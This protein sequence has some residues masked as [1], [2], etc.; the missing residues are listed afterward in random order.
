M[1]TLRLTTRDQARALVDCTYD[2]YG[3]TFH[4]DWVYDADRVMELNA[5][6]DVVSFLAM[7]GRDVVGHVAMLRPSFDVTDEGCPITSMACREVGL[8]MVRPTHQGQGVQAQISVAMMQ[9]TMQSD[10]AGTFMKCVT[11]HTG[12]QKGARRAGGVPTGLMLGSIP[13]WVCYDD[14]EQASDQPISVVQYHITFRPSEKVLQVPQ[15][16]EWLPDV[17]ANTG[18]TRLAPPPALV[19]GDTRLVVKWQ[20][21]RKLAQIYVMEAGRDL[22]EKL[23]ERIQWLMGGHIAHV[24]VYMPGDAPAVGAAGPDLAAAGLSPA[25]WIPDFF[26]GRRDAILYQALTHQKLDVE[27]IRVAGKDA[28]SLAKNV[29]SGWQQTRDAQER[30]EAAAAAAGSVVSLDAARRSRELAS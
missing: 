30:R 26:R 12:S 22:V 24:L 23:H 19:D 7:D 2:T 14:E 21:D 29:H 9:Y 1:E 20:G 10:I 18:T 8:S 17:V 3:L 5:R 15:G 16:F 4:R 11:K 13:R 25:G 27:N 28:I 6:G